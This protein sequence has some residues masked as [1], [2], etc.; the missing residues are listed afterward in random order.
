LDN[1]LDEVEVVSLLDRG[2]RGLAKARALA[3]PGGDRRTKDQLTDGQRAYNRLQAGLRALV[4]QAIGHLGNAWALRRWAG[5]AVPDPR[6][7]P[8]RRRAPLPLPLAAPDHHLNEHHGH[9]H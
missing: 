7:L 9:P 5:A 6:R 2:F 1:A 4:E 3:R 8:R